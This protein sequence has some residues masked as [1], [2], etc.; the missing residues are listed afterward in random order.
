L[1]TSNFVLTKDSG[2]LRYGN[3]GQ[4]KVIKW[5]MNM[6]RNT[7]SELSPSIGACEFS[8]PIQ[9]DEG[10]WQ[11]NVLSGN[12]LKD[13]PEDEEKEGGWCIT[14]DSEDLV[15]NPHFPNAIEE[16]EMGTDG[17]EEIGVDEEDEEESQDE[18]DR[19]EDEDNQDDMQTSP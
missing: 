17:E 9:W 14:D 8:Q 15:N 19:P 13:H 16:L 3:E 11:S 7:I 2:P 18:H 1:H 5:Y 6:T 12:V 10:T 4:T